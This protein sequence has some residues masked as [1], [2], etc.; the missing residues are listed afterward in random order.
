MTG[1]CDELRLLEA[2]AGFG[3]VD[4]SPLAPLA[5]CTIV[6]PV[7]RDKLVMTLRGTEV[8][9]DFTH[10]LA[11]ECA[12]RLRRDR[13]TPVR[14]T[15]SQRVVRA[16]EIPK[17][18]GDSHH[19]RLFT[20]ATDDESESTASWADALIEHVRAL[21]SGFDELTQEGY[22]FRRRS[23]RLLATAARSADRI[24]EQLA[25]VEAVVCG[26][27]DHRITTVC[28]S[29][30]SASRRTAASSRSPTAAPSSES[31][32][33]PPTAAWCSWRVD[34]APSW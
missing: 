34:W 23:V 2:A 11:L 28:A 14:L 24:S 25:P 19:F 22:T 18:P 20:L 10:V 31:P 9:S 27:L 29:R 32:G 12:R 6:G 15:T 7:R 5:T 1:L 4:P 17:R 21:R 3:A 13:D 30:S 26:P 16:Q 33:W 8:V